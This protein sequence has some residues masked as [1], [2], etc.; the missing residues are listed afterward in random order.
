MYMFSRMKDQYD[1]LCSFSVLW[2]RAENTAEA[3]KGFASKTSVKTIAVGLY[4]AYD[5]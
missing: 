1:A 4:T 2:L 3:F 5:H